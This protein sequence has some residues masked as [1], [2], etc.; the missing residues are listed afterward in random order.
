VVVE[1]WWLGEG[2]AVVLG[3]GVGSG[4][5]VSMCEHCQ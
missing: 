5:G 2:E 4:K 1:W 3:G